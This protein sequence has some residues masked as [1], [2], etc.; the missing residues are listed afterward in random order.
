MKI[1]S[2]VLALAIL[3]LGGA[4]AWAGEQSV[5][6]AI[7]FGAPI[8]DDEILTL[9]HTHNARPYAVYMF[10]AGLSGTHRVSPEE[11]SEEAVIKARQNTIRGVGGIL[12]ESDGEQFRDILR[13][14]K[15][16]N[17][18][19]AS[20]E[21]QALA[22]S[23]VRQREQD[24]ILFKTASENAPL[25]HALEVVVDIADAPKLA[26]HPLVKKASIGLW[27]KRGPIVSR[28]RGLSELHRPLL[29]SMTPAMLYREIER[30][31]K[32]HREEVSRAF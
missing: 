12:S 24:L 22:E 4:A 28:P 2:I 29:E 7:S 15:G 16:L 10:A 13:K 27:S 9:L 17:G 6:M 19:E 1:K 5:P 21:L 31:A 20:P 14:A 26:A 11:A 3:S 8:A 32:S 30:L 25:V 18:F 23:R